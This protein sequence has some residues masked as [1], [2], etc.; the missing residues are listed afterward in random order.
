[1]DLDKYAFKEYSNEN[2]FNI[3]IL[4][5]NSHVFFDNLTV[6]GFINYDFIKK[7]SIDSELYGSNIYLKIDNEKIFYIK[8]IEFF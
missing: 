2:K 5:P 6:Y 8:I 4:K 1:M 3:I 7:E